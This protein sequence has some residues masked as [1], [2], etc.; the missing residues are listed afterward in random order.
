MTQL[1]VLQPESSVL[2]H[3]NCLGSFSK[4]PDF[5]KV[6]KTKKYKICWT[7]KTFYHVG[8][9]SFFVKHVQH[10]GKLQPHNKKQL[11]YKVRKNVSQLTKV[12]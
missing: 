2:N 3:D 8:E 9:Q 11:T 5:H 4:L 7:S 6:F 12:D 10:S 1:G